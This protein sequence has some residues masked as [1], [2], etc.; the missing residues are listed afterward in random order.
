[1]PASPAAA[2]GILLAYYDRHIPGA[3]REFQA[4]MADV[5]AGSPVIVVFNGAQQPEGLPPHLIVVRGDNSLREFSGWQAGLARARELGLIA[6]ATLLVLAN[7]TFCHHRPFGPVSRLVF[8]H[9]FRRMLYQRRSR[10]YAG[11][12]FRLGAPCSLA[13]KPVEQ[14]VSTYLFA[15][16]GPLVSALDSL[17]PPF[18]LQTCF[19]PESEP[20]RFLTGPVSDDLRR[21]IEG[22]LFGKSRAAWYGARE[23]TAE[24]RQ[25][26]VG[27]CKSILCEVHLAAAAREQGA[28]LVPVAGPRLMGLAR[29]LDALAVRPF[30]AALP[31]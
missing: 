2:V 20:D 19:A 22:W 12:T 29:R 10:L 13:G 23:L 30:A 17:L 14:W 6:P 1:M 21:H 26:L 27:K 11:E 5:S 15:M 18:D 28:T 16:S 3:V 25:G 4:L 7:D 24:T 31:Q 9:A 8:A